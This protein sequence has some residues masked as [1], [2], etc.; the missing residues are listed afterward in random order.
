MSSDW[1]REHKERN[2]TKGGAPMVGC[3]CC[4][5][6]ERKWCRLIIVTGRFPMSS[7]WIRVHKVTNTTE[8]GALMEGVC[9]A[10]RAK[11][12]GVDS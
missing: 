8:G 4:L 1:V 2:A 7:D 5:Q 12:R 11:E 3:L 6:G 9:V 10:F